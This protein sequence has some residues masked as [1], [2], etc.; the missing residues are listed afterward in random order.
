VLHA[1]GEISGE[2]ILWF[3]I[4]IAVLI[5]SAWFLTTFS[6]ARQDPAALTGDLF[7]LVA[8]INSGCTASTYSDAFNPNTEEG[9]LE[10]EGNQLCF[11]RDKTRIC[12]KPLCG[13]YDGVSIDLAAIKNVRITIVEG[14][15]T[16]AGE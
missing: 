7:S 3:G 13:T 1:R 12:K 14:A 16:L 8:S 11:A 10:G 5:S 2:L 15:V 9:L 4:I 6:S